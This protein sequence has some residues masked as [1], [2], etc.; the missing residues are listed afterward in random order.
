MPIEI[1]SKAFF[2]GLESIPIVWR[3]IKITGWLIL[4]WLLKTYF[5]GARNTSERNMHSKV[6]L[7]TVCG[8]LAL[9]INATLTD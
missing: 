4:I 5:G 8:T 3:G 7:M 6:V 1:A 2:D 9:L